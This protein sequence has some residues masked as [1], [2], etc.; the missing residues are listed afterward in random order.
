[1]ST[2]RWSLDGKVALVTGATR[3]IGYA[4]AREYL[5]RGASVFFTARR[6]EELDAAESSLSAY[7]RVVTMAASAGD[8]VAIEA[9]ASACVEQLGTIDIL[10]NNAATNPSPDR[11]SRLTWPRSTSSGVNLVG[12]LL[13]RDERGTVDE[14]EFAGMV[15]LDVE[16]GQRHRSRCNERRIRRTGKRHFSISH[17]NSQWN[18]GPTSE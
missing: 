14:I 9:S 5:E 11:S 15:P 8:A 16:V 4:I 12:P 13:V 17:V 18:S 2:S 6:Q 1:M 7:G 3:G 10:V